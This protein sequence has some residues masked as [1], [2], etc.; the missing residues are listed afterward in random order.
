M[1]ARVLPCPLARGVEAMIDVVVDQRLL[2]LANR[3]LDGVK[4]LGDIETGPS[5]L[6]HADDAAE[7]SLRASAASR[8]R[9]GFGGLDYCLACARSYPP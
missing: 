6:D 1:T 2:G 9:D 7:M 5:F 8:C 4:L 3:L